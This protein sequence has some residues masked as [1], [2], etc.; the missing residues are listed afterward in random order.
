MGKQIHARPAAIGAARAAR[1]APVLAAVLL[2]A[3][4]LFLT[5]CGAS[6][7]SEL[8]A[9]GPDVTAT[10]SGLVAEPVTASKEKAVRLPKA[11]DAFASAATPGSAAYKIGPQDVLDI[12]VFKAPELARSVQVAESGTINLP[13]VGEVHAVGK[14]AQEVERDLAKRLRAK[15][16]QSPQV[17]VYV[18]EFNSQRVTIEGAVKKPGVYPLRGKTTLMHFIAMAEGLDPTSDSSNIVIFRRVDGKRFAAKFDIAQIR[19]GKAEDPTIVQGDLIV[20]HA[21][22]MKAAWQDLL[23]ALP[24]G[25]A[26]IPLL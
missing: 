25:A 15:Y 1:R 13:L 17:T 7:N 6:F 8:P 23:R 20:A 19:E 10:R 24:V 21:S 12:S 16:M 18:K 9:A 11:A 22:A 3:G 2:A 5:G 26:F 4:G 14:T